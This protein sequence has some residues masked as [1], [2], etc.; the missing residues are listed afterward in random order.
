[1]ATTVWPGVRLLEMLDGI[2]EGKRDGFE[3]LHGTK[4]TTEGVHFDTLYNDHYYNYFCDVNNNGGFSLVLHPD[5]KPFAE[6]LGKPSV[7]K[8]CW[9]GHNGDPVTGITA[10]MVAERYDNVALKCNETFDKKTGWIDASGKA[11]ETKDDAVR[12]VFGPGF[13]VVGLEQKDDDNSSVRSD[14]LLDD[15]AFGEMKEKLLA[16]VQSATVSDA[17]LRTG[18]LAFDPEAAPLDAAD[19]TELAERLVEQLMYETDDESSDDDES[20][21]SDDDDEPDEPPL[22]ER[23]AKRSRKA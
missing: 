15:N 5:V 8:H 17:W 23:P 9:F 20:S 1:M 11:W 6:A 3:G 4:T 18:V 19:R 21:A 12:E 16:R 13:K 10:A 2:V 7:M 22:E 14:D